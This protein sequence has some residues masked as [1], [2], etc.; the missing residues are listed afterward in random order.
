TTASF[1]PTTDFVDLPGGAKKF[2]IRF[3]SQSKAYWSLV[4]PAMPIAR[5]QQRKATSIRNTLALMRSTDLKHWEMR[6]LL[7][8]HPDV[9]KHGFQYPDWQFDGDDLIAAIRTAY[10]D[11][12]GGAHNFHDAN[13]LTFHRFVDF[14]T[15]TM[16]DSV[17]EP[18]TLELPP[19]TRIETD[20]LVV[21]GHTIALSSLEN[22]HRA[23]A[24]RTYVWQQLPTALQ[25]W[26][27]MQSLG[28]TSTPISVTA[29]HD[30]II[31]IATAVSQQSVDTTGWQEE[32]QWSFCY[33]DSGRT[34]MRVLRR[35]IT[36][37]EQVELP[38]GNWTGGVLLIPPNTKD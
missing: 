38:Q 5:L 15:L 7:L 35:V 21:E 29:R 4:N 17:V 1:D 30:T 19:P 6:C 18:Q 37:G 11:G 3:D 31:Y 27:F 9:A 25:G 20:S 23:F 32:P 16:A 13:F 22:G 36:A 10:D 12:L 26:R 2:T 24:N 8:Y 34:R 14:R 33:T 28:G